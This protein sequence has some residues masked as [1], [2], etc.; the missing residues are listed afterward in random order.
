MADYD[1]IVV[2]SGH[3]GLVAA[4]YLARAGWRVIV[5]ERA[6]Q[7]GGA[8]TT[9]EVTL[10]GFRHD[11]FSTNMALFRS[12]TAYQELRPEFDRAGLQFLVS[13]YPYAS[14]YPDGKAARVYKDPERTAEEFAKHSAA[15]LQGWKEVVGL[16]Q[17]TAPYLL[18]IL[19]TTLP[20]WAAGRH[21]WRMFRGIGASG[22]LEL[23]HVILKSPRGYVDSFFHTDE[24]KGLFIPWGLHGDQGPEVSGGAAFLFVTAISH[25]LHGQVAARGGTGNVISAL[26]SLIEEKGGVIRTRAEVARVLVERGRAAGVRTAAGETI[27]VSRAVIANV[28]PPVLFGSL[29]PPDAL[30]AAFKTRAAR[31][32]YGPGSFMVHLALR[33]PLAWNSGDDLAR[34]SY[35]HLNGKPDEV[36]LTY[37]QA[38]AGYLPAR[39]V[40]VVA[41]QTSHDPTRAPAGNHTL[42]V[43]VR[44]VPARINGDASGVIGG[45]DWDAIKEQFAARIIDL[46]AEHAP[47]TKSAI[48]GAY[49]MSPVDLERENPNLVGGDCVSGSHHLDQNYFFRPFPGWSRYAT[50]VKGLYM[51]GAFTWPGG[52][53][54]ATSGYLL[55]RRLLRQ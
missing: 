25:H 5:L 18:P 16:Y 32:R 12:S 3:N 20:S 17:R 10:P 53:V 29:V 6:D 45:R 11:I 48:L 21:L 31:Y 30:P 39:P 27:T 22:M 46:L 14:T 26:R 38:M 47:N 8:M 13:D 50:P 55:A 40:L 36:S 54:N 43:Q 9:R 4:L 41:Q 1:A 52:G 33:E 51:V 15:D 42:W 49:F 35:V 28:T 34:F 24:V 7:P 37:S 44:A 2:G 19:K 23:S